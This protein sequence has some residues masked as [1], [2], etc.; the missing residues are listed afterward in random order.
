VE[1]PTARR[2]PAGEVPTK[3]GGVRGNLSLLGVLFRAC[4]GRY[5]PSAATT[6]PTGSDPGA[7]RV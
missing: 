3:I 5:D 1:L 6:G 4:L 2:Y 7:T